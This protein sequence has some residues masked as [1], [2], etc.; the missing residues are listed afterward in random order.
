VAVYFPFVNDKM[1]S[2]AAMAIYH[3]VPDGGTSLGAS[4]GIP[5]V[6]G[7]IF[8]SRAKGKFLNSA[9]Q[10]KRAQRLPK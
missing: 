10:L 3:Y 1:G 7:A 4:A 2:L 8:G 5:F 6:L 9:R